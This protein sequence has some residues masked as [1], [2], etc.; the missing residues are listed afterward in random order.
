MVNN[1][2]NFFKVYKDTTSKT[3]FVAGLLNFICY[4]SESVVGGHFSTG[5][6]FQ[7]NYKVSYELTF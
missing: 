5:S 1:I 6:V 4:I 2:K 3:A 7:E